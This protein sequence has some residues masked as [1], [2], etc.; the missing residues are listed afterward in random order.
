MFP[1]PTT[2][3][4]DTPH[5]GTLFRRSS[6]RWGFDATVK[7]ISRLCGYLVLV[8]DTEHLFAMRGLG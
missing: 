8:W 2:P 6:G 1:N 3:T 5:S 4:I 7:C